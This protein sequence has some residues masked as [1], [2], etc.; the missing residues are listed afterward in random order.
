MV[1][2]YGERSRRRAHA[3]PRT[4]R[5]FVPDASSARPR[6]PYRH[7][8]YGWLWNVTHNVTHRP[9]GCWASH[10]FVVCGDGGNSDHG[11]QEAWGNDTQAHLV[12]R[13]PF[14]GGGTH[15]CGRDNAVD[16]ERLGVLLL[17]K[18]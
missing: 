12:Q 18:K 10:P 14:V 15:G 2:S 5:F 13:R 11:L 3:H 7:E 4:I 6:W 17:K 16:I 1:V 8:R 9:W